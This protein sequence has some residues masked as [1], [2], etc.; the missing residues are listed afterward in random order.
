VDLK[1]FLQVMRRRWRSVVAMI[2]VAVAVA[3]GAIYLQTPQ[4]ES[5]ARVFLSVDFTN[6][7]D[8]YSAQAFL[9]QRAASYADIAESSELADRVIDALNLQETA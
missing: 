5:K 6:L 2:V 1:Q 7:T 8:A 3:G 4:Y 9:S